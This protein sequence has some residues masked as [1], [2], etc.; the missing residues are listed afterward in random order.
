MLQMVFLLQISLEQLLGGTAGGLQMPYVQRASTEI[1][2]A[3]IEYQRGKDALLMLHPCNIL[4]RNQGSGAISI[5]LSTSSHSNRVFRNYD[6]KDLPPHLE[7]APS[8]TLER[9][10]KLMSYDAPEVIAGDLCTVASDVWSFGCLIFYMLTGRHLFHGAQPAVMLSAIFKH[11][12]YP[13]QR[14]VSVIESRP[15]LQDMLKTTLPDCP[16]QATD[17]P[18]V[19]R[20]KALLPKNKPMLQLLTSCLSIDP[21][22]RPSTSQLLEHPVLS[23]Y[24]SSLDQRSP[25]AHESIHDALSLLPKNPEGTPDGGGHHISSSSEV[26]Q[27]WTR[28]SHDGSATQKVLSACS[29][30]D[31]SLL[32]RSD[33]IPDQDQPATASY[34]VIYRRVS[35][36]DLGEEVLDTSDDLAAEIERMAPELTVV[37]AGSCS[38]ASDHAGRL[39]AAEELLLQPDAVSAGMH[40]NHDDEDPHAIIE[41]NVEPTSLGN[42]DRSFSFNICPEDTLSPVHSHHVVKDSKSNLMFSVAERETSS[43]E[44]F[45]TSPPLLGAV[46]TSAASVSTMNQSLSSWVTP[47]FISFP[48]LAAPDIGAGTQSFPHCSQA[49]SHSMNQRSI[50]DPLAPSLHHHHH[51]ECLSASQCASNTASS[52]GAGNFNEHSLPIIRNL[53]SSVQIHDTNVPGDYTKPASSF[54]TGNVADIQLHTEAS[55]NIESSQH[56]LNKLMSFSRRSSSGTALLPSIR[57]SSADGVVAASPPGSRSGSP[58]RFLMSRRVSGSAEGSTSICNGQIAAPLSTPQQPTSSSGEILPVSIEESTGRTVISRDGSPARNLLPRPPSSDSSPSASFSRLQRRSEIASPSVTYDDRSTSSPTGRVPTSHSATAGST[59]SDPA[60]HPEQG[61]SS[62]GPAGSRSSSKLM[63][64]HGIVPKPGLLSKGTRGVSVDGSTSRVMSPLRRVS[65]GGLNHQD[66]DEGSTISHD[67]RG[68]G[69]HQAVCNMVKKKLLYN[70]FSTR[71]FSDNVGGDRLPQ[72]SRRV[73]DNVGGDRLPQVSR[74]FSDFGMTPSLVRSPSCTP[75][76]LAGTRSIVSSNVSSTASAGSPR[77]TSQNST[78]SS[79]GSRE[80][81]LVYVPKQPDKQLSQ[82]GFIAIVAHPAIH[83]QLKPH[84]PNYHPSSTTSLATHPAPNYNNQPQPTSLLYRQ[85]PVVV[86]YFRRRSS[87][88]GQPQLLLNQPQL[89]HNQPQPQW[90]EERDSSKRVMKSI[91]SAPMGGR[92]SIRDETGTP[93]PPKEHYRASDSVHTSSHKEFILSGTEVRAQSATT[94]SAMLHQQRRQESSPSRPYHVH[95]SHHTEG[96]ALP[97]EVHGI[98]S[99]GPSNMRAQAS[100]AYLRASIAPAEVTSPLPL[101]TLKDEVLSM[102]QTAKQNHKK[103]ME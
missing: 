99:V 83:P 40:H 25:H 36:T 89:L 9:R 80:T 61:G 95:T 53:K 70:S 71:R 1:L 15:E 63:Q 28:T 86:A 68:S 49:S 24:A 102:L 39:T 101:P 58:S 21:H 90:Q 103:Y 72:V 94:A 47:D 92:R 44:G 73:S 5:R 60:G 75:C 54:E 52:H 7:Q 34:R 69:D 88:Q 18:L 93:N 77:R 35:S 11:V 6:G 14:L 13:T 76:L 46:H 32:L 65:Y 98:T 20:L 8:L 12:G 16:L 31:S 19:R 100:P 78:C 10:T 3:L 66:E 27:G 30:E 51:Q 57:S 81:K 91:R 26:E 22:L 33:V 41:L 87:E 45:H 29:Y 23:S 97:S 55:P 62:H 56:P 42:L 67:G 96:T 59:L 2:K 79:A 85:D 82:P 37:Q 50:S 17:T 74:R 38:E 4:T 43:I 84:P 48:P 64:D